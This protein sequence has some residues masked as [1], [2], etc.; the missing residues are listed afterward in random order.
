MTVTPNTVPKDAPDWFQWV[1]SRLRVI[2]RHRHGGEDTVTTVS[3][4]FDSTASGWSI[5][6]ASIRMS[7]SVVM[8]SGLCTRTGAT[9]AGVADGNIGD[10]TIG[11]LDFLYWPYQPAAIQAVG[12]GPMRQFQ[13]GPDGTFQVIALGPNVTWATG[14]QAAFAGTWIMADNTS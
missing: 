5:D 13:M 2:E 9:I 8:I 12:A 7:G 1:Q 10:T 3:Q 11:M 4:I 14:V 6:S